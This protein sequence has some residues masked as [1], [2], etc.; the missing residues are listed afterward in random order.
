MSIFRCVTSSNFAY[1]LGQL[2][3]LVVLAAPLDWRDIQFNKLKSGGAVAFTVNNIA[4][5][6]LCEIK[7]VLLESNMINA[8]T[9]SF[10]FLVLSLKICSL[11]D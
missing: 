7:M 1:Q 10:F 11:L 4:V 8:G 3:Q 9:L 2:G 5:I 6:C